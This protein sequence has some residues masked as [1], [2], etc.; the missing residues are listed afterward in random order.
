[1]FRVFPEALDPCFAFCALSHSSLCNAYHWFKFAQEFMGSQR[2][3]TP[4]GSSHADLE[5]LALRF[6]HD[7]SSPITGPPSLPLFLP[8]D[9]PTP[10][11]L[12]LFMPEG[13]PTC[14]HH[15]FHPSPFI[16][17][18]PSHILVLRRMQCKSWT[19]WWTITRGP[20]KFFYIHS[21]R[22]LRTFLAHFFY[23][24]LLSCT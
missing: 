5:E 22:F 20:N 12:P 6:T 17:Q 23:F 15:L 1:M 18:M 16:P 2:A 11:A 19:S 21:W 3:L 7:E 13:S 24:L 14:Q 9:S 8:E 10:P 4:E